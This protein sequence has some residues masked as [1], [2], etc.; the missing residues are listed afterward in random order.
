MIGMVMARVFVSNERDRECGDQ[1]RNERSLFHLCVTLAFAKTGLIARGI[2]RGAHGR[3]PSL[4][5]GS[6]ESSSRLMKVP[7]S[8]DL[9]FFWT[10]L[11]DNFS[12]ACWNVTQLFEFLVGT[13]LGSHGNYGIPNCGGGGAAARSSLDQGSPESKSLSYAVLREIVL[14][15]D[16]MPWYR[17]QR[18]WKVAS[19]DESPQHDALD[20]SVVSALR[21]VGGLLAEGVEC[22]QIKEWLA[23]SGRDLLRLLGGGEQ[24]SWGGCQAERAFHVANRTPGKLQATHVV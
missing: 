24:S 9:I 3:V 14:R 23:H 16:A 20:H 13:V 10:R 4:D 18:Q 15:M 22:I 21:L 7:P 2:S 11:V 19:S 8:R 5:Q 17:R 6:P 1:A 12:E